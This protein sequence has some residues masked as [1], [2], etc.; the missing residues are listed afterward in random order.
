MNSVMS[1][2]ENTISISLFNRGLAGK[3]FSDVRRT[4]AKVVMKNN[5][6]ECVLLSP[7]EYFE[8]YNF[9]CTYRCKKSG[10]RGATKKL[11]KILSDSLNTFWQGKKLYVKDLSLR[12][13]YFEVGGQNCY[14]NDEGEVRILSNTKNPT[15][16]F[17][18]DK[19]DK[20]N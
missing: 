3:I 17:G 10:S 20:I 4:G 15:Y 8:R 1:A 12:E 18:V 11:A 13:T 5:A 2:I 14:I 7:E 19:N 16:I 9:K 6:P